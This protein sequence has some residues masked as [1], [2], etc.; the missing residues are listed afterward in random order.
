MYVPQKIYIHPDDNA[1]PITSSAG[2]PSYFS[3][4]E[5]P[6]WLKLSTKHMKNFLS[7]YSYS[8]WEGS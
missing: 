6:Y 5:G 1:C 3:L 8:G 2:L 7:L 4:K